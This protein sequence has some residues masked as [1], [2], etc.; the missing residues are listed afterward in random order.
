MNRF[1]FSRGRTVDVKMLGPEWRHRMIDVCGIGV[2]RKDT[3]REVF[4]THLDPD[5]L[6]LKE[7]IAG[8]LLK[9]RVPKEYFCH[10]SKIYGELFEV[11]EYS[12]VLRLEHTTLWPGRGKYVTRAAYAFFIRDSMVIPECDNPDQLIKEYGPKLAFVLVSYQSH[13]HLSGFNNYRR[14]VF[15]VHNKVW[16]PYAP[17][18]IPKIVFASTSDDRELFHKYVKSV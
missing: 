12:D 2:Y 7:H 4:I 11:E 8:G 5:H 9:F 13:N 14:D 15:I 10:V 6:P 16:K 17:N 3:W 18:I 1:S